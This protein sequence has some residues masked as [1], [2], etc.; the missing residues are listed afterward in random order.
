VLFSMK[1]LLL[2]LCLL[3]W[4]LTLFG[5]CRPWVALWWSHY[6]PRIKVLRTYGSAAMLLSLLYWLLA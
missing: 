3:M 1:S 5:L 4:V 2:G 6:C